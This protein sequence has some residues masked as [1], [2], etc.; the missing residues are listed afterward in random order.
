MF[1]GLIQRMSEV[2]SLETSSAGGCLGI[3]ATDWP[4][5][6]QVGESIAINGVCLTLTRH[7][8]GVMHFDVLKESL[9][10]TSLRKKVPGTIVNL[11]RAL[12]VGDPMGGHMVTGH[13]D[14]VGIVSNIKMVGRDRSLSIECAPSLLAEM[15]AKGSVACDGVSLT[16]VS[17]D[18]CSF[19]VHIIPHTWDQT[20]FSHVHKGDWINIETDIIGKY[21]RR[22][23]ES[24]GKESRITWETLRKSGFM[25]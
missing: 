8:G 16:I 7:D 23:L 22:F 2:V 15:V 9:E 3:R 1:T 11:E 10:R 12:R 24:T 14:D 17:L 25:Q 19:T 18:D 5:A 6:L 4:L 13:V 21:I 20:A